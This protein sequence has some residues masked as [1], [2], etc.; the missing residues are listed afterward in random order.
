MRVG[1]T[2]HSDA[3]WYFSTHSFPESAIESRLDKRKQ[4]KSLLRRQRKN[5]KVLYV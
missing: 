2:F 1:N 5:S 3:I 4:G